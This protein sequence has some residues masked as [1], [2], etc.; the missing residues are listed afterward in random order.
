MQIVSNIALITIN[1]TLIVQLASFLLFLFIINRVMFRPLRKVISERNAYIDTLQQE[2]AYQQTELKKISKKIRD[3]EQKVL[4]EAHVI[5]L[6]QE[7]A[8][9]HEA[10]E[11]ISATRHEV[12]A[13][14]QKTAKEINDRIMEVDSQLKVEAEAL[15]LRIMEKILDRRIAA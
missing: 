5:V 7:D 14:K 2:I 11:I 10:A 4:H 6:K 12:E 9:S 1:E 13:L 8:G 15:V 3:S